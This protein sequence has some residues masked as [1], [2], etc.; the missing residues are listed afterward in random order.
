MANHAGMSSDPRQ[1]QALVAVVTQ[2]RSGSKWLGSLIRQRYGAIALGEIFNPDDTAVMSY[3]SYLSRRPVD[4]LIGSDAI[5]NLDEYFDS[6]RMYCGLFYTFDVMFNQIDWINFGW[7]EPGKTI[8]R[9]LH[10]RGDIVVSLIRDPRDIFIS[11]KALDLIH[12]AHFTARECAGPPAEGFPAGSLTADRAEYMAFR[13]RLACDRA[14]LGQ[15]F[16]GYDGFIE[17]SYA[18]L[19]RDAAAALQPLDRALRRFG[20]RIGQ[21]F[22]DRISP[23]PGLVRTPVSYASLFANHDEVRDWPA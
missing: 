1:P 2:Q 11:M 17:L 18:D 16:A 3:R 7:S 23:F 13:E 8:Y 22:A 6:I 12:K 21:P 15:A 14:Q 19:E 9:Y 5:A 4:K 10:A 20:E